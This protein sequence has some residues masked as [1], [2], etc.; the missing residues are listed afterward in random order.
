MEL[1]EYAWVN[2]QIALNLSTNLLQ[3]AIPETLSRLKDLE[4]LDLSNNNLSGEIPESLTGMGSL[5]QLILSNNQLD[6]VIPDFKPYVSLNASGNP[7]HKIKTSE[8][9]ARKKG[10]QNGVIIVVGVGAFLLVSFIF[11]LLLFLSEPK[12]DRTRTISVQR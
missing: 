6:G 9:L 2:L 4:I 5:N 1:F 7:G 12:R 10:R 8:K 3:G 11:F